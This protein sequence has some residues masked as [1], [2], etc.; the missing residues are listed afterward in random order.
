MNNGN[1]GQM[2]SSEPMT[3]H[4][5]AYNFDVNYGNQGQMS[6]RLEARRT[7]LPEIG[8]YSR[9][10]NMVA[11]STTG[12]M[13]NPLQEVIKYANNLC[14]NTSSLNKGKNVWDNFVDLTLD[15]P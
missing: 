13:L 5:N 3:S 6:L 7:S 1:Q 2:S 8:E 12:S 10:P 14:P 15:S 4:L 11:K 9:N